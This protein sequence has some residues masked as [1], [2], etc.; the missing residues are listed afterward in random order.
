MV[1]SFFPIFFSF[2]LG[3]W[4]DTFG[5]KLCIFLFM[6]TRIL[7]QAV[8]ILLAYNMHWAKEWFLLTLVPTTLI[9]IASHLTLFFMWALRE[10]FSIN[11]FFMVYQFFADY[12]ILICFSLYVI[13]CLALTIKSSCE[14][15]PKA[16][17]IHSGYYLSEARP[18]RLGL[19]FILLDSSAAMPFL[20]PILMY[21]AFVGSL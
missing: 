11:Q 18:G 4:C 8:L 2:Y 14:L 9:G 1:T 19:L 7:G 16:L 10:F 17:L 21:I 5:R 12:T 15:E 20:A 6:F 3:A 13:L